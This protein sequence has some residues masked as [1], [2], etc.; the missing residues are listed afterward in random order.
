MLNF[1]F[2]KAWFWLASPRNF[3][4]DFSRIMFFIL[5]SINWPNF[6]DWLPLLLG[7]WAYVYC[8]ICCSVCERK[9]PSRG[10][11]RK[12]CSENM[13][14]IYRRT[15]MP[16]CDFIKFIE[17]TLQLG[18]SPVN[19]LHTFRTLF[20]KNT[21]GGLLLCEVINLQINNH[22]FLIKPFFYITKN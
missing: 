17:I 6:I 3:V 8:S 7:Y 2:L 18:C 22:S 4:Y 13:Q 16:K 1:D 9:Q 10:F 12:S 11:L 15:P 20:H 14:E 19:L 21:Y 5:Y